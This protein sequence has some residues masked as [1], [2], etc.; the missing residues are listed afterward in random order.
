MKTGKLN[1]G[2]IVGVLL[3]ALGGCKQDLPFPESTDPVFTA[4]ATIG[5]ETLSWQAG[6]NGCVMKTE[7]AIDG[8]DIRIFSGD[9]AGGANGELDIQIRD[10][11]T[12][13]NGDFDP[14]AVF[15][16]GD[17]FFVGQVDPAEAFTF[18]FRATD[19][20]QTEGKTY[21]WE[22]GDGNTS[23][24]P[25]PKHTYQAEGVYEVRLTIVDAKGCT[26]L[27]RQMVNVGQSY[28]ECGLDFT[29]EILDPTRVRLRANYK[30]GLG[31]PILV[32]TTG[33]G[34]HYTK[35]ETV[36]HTYESPGIYEI[37]LVATF[38]SLGT[39]CLIKNIYTGPGASCISSSE[40]TRSSLPLDLGRV[41]LN[42]TDPAGRRYT[43]QR[44]ESQPSE[45]L[46]ELISFEPYLE[47]EEGQSTYKIEAR[48][49]C[50]LYAEDDPDEILILENGK[51][52]FAVAVPS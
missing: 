3:M 6:S 50:E 14:E 28:L 51:A 42:Y 9:F 48:F 25:N 45:S 40:F 23:N 1:W 22:F 43:S 4:S 12:L 24:L 52:V 38:K 29:Y 11:V 19:F 39:C 33:D 35:Q 30:Q 10:V 49:N 47:N 21:L 5:E 20:G 16:V 37:K 41:S 2:I 31:D 36:D 34:N 27:A 18:S 46:F 8:T 7:W 15:A 26:S 44:F 17:R 13:G 32:W